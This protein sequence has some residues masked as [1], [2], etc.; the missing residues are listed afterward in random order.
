MSR[1]RIVA[2]VLAVCLLVAVGFGVTTNQKLENS[3]KLVVSTKAD[4]NDTQDTLVN[5]RGSLNDTEASLNSAETLNQTAAACADY[6][7]NDIPNKTFKN[8]II[9][10]KANVA[11]LV[12]MCQPLLDAATTSVENPTQ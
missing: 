5:V 11:T 10:T 1:D 8:Y 12:D 3:N 9:L 6:L 2:I 4:L 7:I